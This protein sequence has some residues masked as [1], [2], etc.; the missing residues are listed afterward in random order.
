MR[1]FNFNDTDDLIIAEHRKYMELQ[2]KQNTT[3]SDATNVDRRKTVFSIKK[4]RTE[5]KRFDRENIL[6]RINEEDVH[7]IRPSI[8]VRLITQ[9]FHKK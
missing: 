4:K 6:W 8:F 7:T 1:T 3:T 9:F 5:D 2:M